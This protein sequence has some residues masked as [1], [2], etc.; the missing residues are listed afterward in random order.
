M[1]ITPVIPKAAEDGAEL[2]LSV[3][4][5]TAIGAAAGAAAGTTTVGTDA[6]D[7]LAIYGVKHFYSLRL[8]KCLRLFLIVYLRI[9]T[10]SAGVGIGIGVLGPCSCSF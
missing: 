9:V 2:C 8:V 3:L 6:L 4:A 10:T 7:D 1:I 5:A